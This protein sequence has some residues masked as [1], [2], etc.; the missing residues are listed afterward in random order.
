MRFYGLAGKHP[1][2]RT[3]ELADVF[4]LLREHF[5]AARRPLSLI[6]AQYLHSGRRRLFGMTG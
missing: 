6:S 4:G 1:T 2:A 3:L 5:G